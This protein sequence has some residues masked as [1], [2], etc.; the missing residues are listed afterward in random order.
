K[1]WIAKFKGKFD[2]GWDKVREETLARQIQL[3]VVPKGT[4]LVPMPKGI[5]P[6]AKLSADQKKVYARMMEVYAGYLAFTDHNIGRVI[7]AIEE[8]GQLDNTLIIYIMGDNGASAEGSLQGTT[9]EI[10]TAAN[11]VQEDM[12]YLLSMLDKLGGPQGYNHYPVG[13]AQAMCTPFGWMKQV[14]SHFGGTRNGL[15]ISWPKQIKEQHYGLRKQF[16]HIIDIVPTI[17]EAVGVEAP[18]TINGT[19]QRPIEGVSM[20]YSF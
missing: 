7:E 6:W 13:W 3:G 5:A 1:E 11:G 17:L 20:M 10:G 9:N 12:K 14:A 8:S 16:H 2:Q 19:P 18:L 4:Q 15:V